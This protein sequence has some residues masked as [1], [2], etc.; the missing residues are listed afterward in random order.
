MSKHRQP[1]RGPFRTPF[2]P[3]RRK[4][5]AGMAAA[6]GAIA[7]PGCGGS[8]VSSAVEE[9]VGAGALPN[10][11]DSGIDYIVQVMMENRSYDH[12][13]GWVPNSDG[14]QAGLTFKNVEG[15]DVETFHLASDPAYGYQGCGWA[16]PDHGYEA[17]RVHMNGG[18]MDGWLLTGGT[19][20]DPADK[21]PVG[22][23]KEEDLP[24][25]AGVAKHFTI[26]DQYF[27]GILAQTFPNRMYIHAGATDRLVNN[28]PWAQQ[29]PSTLPTI[30]DRLAA[31]GVSGLNYFHD[32]PTPGLWGDKY[33]DII[34]PYH[35]FLAD[36]AAGT[37][38][39]VS[40]IDPYFGASVGESPAGV[41]RDDHPQADVRDGQHFLA[42]VYNALRTSPVWDRTLMIVT[43]DEW[44]G[45]YDHVVPP[46]GPISPEEAAVGNDGTL[47]FRVPC[48]ILG[49]RAQR[50]HVSHFRFDPNSV[51]N[52]ITW[53]F[54]LEKLSAR[55]DWSH[56]LAMAL[57]FRNPPNLDAPD[58]GVP[59]G[60]F[61]TSP[62]Y[63]AVT[64]PGMPGVGPDAATRS[65]LEHQ[66]EW[67]GFAQFCRKHGLI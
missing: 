20:D 67:D 48:V 22:Y 1:P 26:C 59:M 41:S 34:R 5:L 42:E 56:N 53:R 54:G 63:Q 2:D 58:F 9:R 60:P 40:Y 14:L 10:P 55:A 24:F 6:T 15:K 43:Y 19:S 37:L 65:M 50:G 23:Y 17:G 28:L 32:L 31:K 11:E 57:D 29:D 52:L 25:Y 66:S 3:G 4:F 46:V 51:I 39:S 64:G 33:K 49:P 12:F 47:G 35:S 45:F 30:W 21:F 18:A 36:C 44:G 38:P 7:L 8:S 13:L 16:D 27:H 62:C 61:G